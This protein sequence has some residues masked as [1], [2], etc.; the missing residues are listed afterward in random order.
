MLFGGG[1]E[2]GD[3]AAAERVRIGAVAQQQVETVEVLE[4]DEV[5]RSTE[6]VAAVGVG[7]AAQQQLGALAAVVLYRQLQRLL[8]QVVVTASSRRRRCRRR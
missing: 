4:R 7:A 8:G 6:E 1:H 2:C 5:D 3:A